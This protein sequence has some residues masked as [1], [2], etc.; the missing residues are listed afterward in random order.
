MGSVENNETFRNL[1]RELFDAYGEQPDLEDTAVI[2]GRSTYFRGEQKVGDVRHTQVWVKSFLRLTK[3]VMAATRS[4][5][6]TGL[7]ICSW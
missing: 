5:G 6:S 4:V 7:A 2:T 3:L 1:E